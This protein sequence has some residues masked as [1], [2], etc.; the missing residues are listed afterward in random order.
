MN[1][2]EKAY[3]EGFKDAAFLRL[4]RSQDAEEVLREFYWPTSDAKCAADIA[5]NFPFWPHIKAWIL[6]RIKPRRKFVWA[7]PPDHPSCRCVLTEGYSAETP[8]DT[9]DPPTRT[10]H[11]KE[12]GRAEGGFVDGTFRT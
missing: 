9:S 11:S 1:E 2:I 10:D 8:L 7:P 3:R 5:A 12:A 6:Q 4:D